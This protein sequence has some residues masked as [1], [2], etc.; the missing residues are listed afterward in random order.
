M[1]RDVNERFNEVNFPLF[2]LHGT[3]DHLCL[4]SGSQTLYDAAPTKNKLLKVNLIAYC[5][6]FNI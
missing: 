5:N 6:K 2:I 4:P 3:D 1:I